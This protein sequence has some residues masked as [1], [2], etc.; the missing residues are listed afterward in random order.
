METIF[1][2]LTVF[3]F[4]VVVGLFLHFSQKGEQKILPYMLPAAGCAAANFAGNNNYELVAWCLIAM[5]CGYVYL[6]IFRKGGAPMD[7]EAL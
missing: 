2:F 7:D 5:L 6:A 4:V 1:D 3:I